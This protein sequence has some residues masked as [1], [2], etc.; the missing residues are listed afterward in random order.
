MRFWTEHIELETPRPVMMVPVKQQVIVRF[1]TWHHRTLL[2]KNKKNLS[3]VKIYL[4]LTSLKFTLLKC[5]QAKVRGNRNV[6]FVFA[7]VN[8]TLCVK[9][10]T[11]YF[12]YFNSKK[13]LDDILVRL[14]QIKFFPTLS[15][16]EMFFGG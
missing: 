15:C 12:K 16:F 6:D 13:Q 8:C 11:G 10:V 14:N 1:T 5:C 2:Y 3:Q 9:L 4:D 7:D